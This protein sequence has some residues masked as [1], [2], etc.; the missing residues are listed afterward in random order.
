EESKKKEIN[1]SRDEGLQKAV[2][3]IEQYA[4]SIMHEH[5]YP[6]DFQPTDSYYEDMGVYH[7]HFPFIKN[8]VVVEGFGLNVGISTDKGTLVHFNSYP[9]EIDHWPSPKE[10]VSSEVALASFQ[11]EMDIQLYYQ[12]I[13][14]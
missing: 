8:G 13:T 2:A 11:K 4:P 12:L 14:D 6:D 10:V 3:F 7:Y 5:S 1:L 9:F